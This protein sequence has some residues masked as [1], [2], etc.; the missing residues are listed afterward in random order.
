MYTDICYAPTLSTPTVIKAVLI[1]GAQTADGVTGGH[2]GEG[3]APPDSRLAIPTVCRSGGECGL[4]TV[5]DDTTVT[6]TAPGTG[7]ET[8]LSDTALER[9]EFL[10][11]DP[12]LGPAE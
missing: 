11:R 7:Q 3:I 10:F 4:V 9:M 5:C 12:E 8:M 1:R 6:C 2:V